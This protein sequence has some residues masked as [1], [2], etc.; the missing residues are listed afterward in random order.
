[1]SEVVNDR[2]FHPSLIFAGKPG[3]HQ[4]GAIMGHY[5]QILDYG[6]S[7]WQWKT[8][9]LI[10]ICLQLRPLRFYSAGTNIIQLYIAVMNSTLR[11][12]VWICQCHS[13]LTKKITVTDSETLAILEHE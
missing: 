5:L 7:E 3:V 11:K 6:R 10:T 1:V 2:H 8:L 4:S 13:V 12:L 9:Q